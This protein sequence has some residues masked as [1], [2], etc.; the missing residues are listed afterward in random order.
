MAVPTP[1]R[2]ASKLA[3]LA[4]LP[5]AGG[6]YLVSPLP[7]A[8]GH[9]L[10]SPLPLAGGAGGGPGRSHPSRIMERSE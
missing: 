10:L 1:L 6:R 4:V 2:L 7:L 8:G 3:S 5:L 9:Y